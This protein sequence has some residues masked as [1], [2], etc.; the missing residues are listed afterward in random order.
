ME[1]C[2]KPW[3]D[4]DVNDVNDDVNVPFRSLPIQ[5]INLKCFCVK[6][7]EKLRLNSCKPKEGFSCLPQRLG[8]PSNSTKSLT[9][10]LMHANVAIWLGEMGGQ[11]GKNQLD[12]V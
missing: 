5:L 11:Y 10:I 2:K 9:K 4:D 6:S 12:V 7:P 3:R 1:T 8:T